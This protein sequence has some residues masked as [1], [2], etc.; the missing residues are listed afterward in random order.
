MREDLPST[1][2]R[3]QLEGPPTTKEGAKPIQQI[4]FI[5]G[6]LCAEPCIECFT[7][8]ITLDLPTKP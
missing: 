4:A 7:Y 8:I 2:D 1:G 6:L 3:A 5:P